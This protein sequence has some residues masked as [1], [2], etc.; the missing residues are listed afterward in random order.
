ML[1]YDATVWLMHIRKYIVYQEVTNDMEKMEGPEGV[2]RAGACV[3]RGRSVLN[4][5]VSLM[6]SHFS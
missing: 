3:C 5:I 1:N 4:R 6:E 2:E